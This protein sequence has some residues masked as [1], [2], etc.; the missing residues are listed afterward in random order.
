LRLSDFARDKYIIDFQFYSSI[1]GKINF[2]E[3]CNKNKQKEF[4]YEFIIFING[5]K[6]PYKIAGRK[7]VW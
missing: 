1:E 4:Y 2:V 7:T 3:K 5:Q 6:P